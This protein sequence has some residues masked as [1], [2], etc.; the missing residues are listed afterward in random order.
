MNLANERKSIHMLIKTLFHSSVVLHVSAPHSLFTIHC[1]T[2]SNV[3]Y[4]TSSGC[5][6]LCS[7]LDFPWIFIVFPLSLWKSTFQFDLRHNKSIIIQVRFPSPYSWYIHNFFCPLCTP[8]IRSKTSHA[9]LIWK[10]KTFEK[11]PQLSDG[12]QEIAEPNEKKSYRAHSTFYLVSIKQI[13][14]MTKMYKWINVRLIESAEVFIGHQI[15]PFG[16]F[17]AVRAINRPVHVY[18][19]RI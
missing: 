18:I 11:W 17:I 15:D 14:Y 6:H 1:C 13:K 12:W 5:R 9:S 3:F 4:G 2:L 7:H 19:N 10:K 16:S 8:L